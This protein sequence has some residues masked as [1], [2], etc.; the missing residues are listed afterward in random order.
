MSHYAEVVD[1]KIN[2]V[3][4]K[5]VSQVLSIEADEVAKR[6]GTWIQ[7]SYNTVG[8]VHSAGGTPLRGNYAGIGSIYDPVND[9]FYTQRPFPSWTISGPSWIW[10]SPVPM[11]TDGRAYGWNESTKSW[12]AWT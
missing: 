5:V 11:P 10:Q 3:D 4:A 2:G 8:G 1:T 6:P 9:V 12:D 7:T